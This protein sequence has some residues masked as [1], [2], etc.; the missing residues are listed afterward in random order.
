MVLINPERPRPVREYRNAGAFGAA[1]ADRVTETGAPVRLEVV[2]QV[3]AKAYVETWVDLVTFWEGPWSSDIPMPT[4]Q[5]LI[6]AG[7]SVGA[8]YV[9][10]VTRTKV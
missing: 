9:R 3:R 7:R 10:A 6:A 4:E 8:R 2:I 1:V 5:D